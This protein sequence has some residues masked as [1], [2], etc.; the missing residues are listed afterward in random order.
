MSLEFFEFFSTFEFFDIFSFILLQMCTGNVHHLCIELQRN[1]N[2]EHKSIYS[3]ID[4]SAS[5]TNQLSVL[6]NYLEMFFIRREN[7]LRNHNKCDK[8][9]WSTLDDIFLLC[10]LS[11]WLL[12][13]VKNLKRYL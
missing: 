8:I 6:S 7:L 12:M 5:Y 1:K 10:R 4:L 2:V 3:E 13:N 11:I 9:R